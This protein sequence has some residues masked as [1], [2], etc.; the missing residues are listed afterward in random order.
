LPRGGIEGKRI[1]TEEV[2][3]Y[4]NPAKNFIKLS[5]REKL[6]YYKILNVLGKV[7]QQGYYNEEGISLNNTISSGHYLLYVQ[8]ESGTQGYGRLVVE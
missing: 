1:S 3:I 6:E 7:V 8:F 4:P 5:H 2:L